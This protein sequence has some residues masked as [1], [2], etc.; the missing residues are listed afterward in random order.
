M[1]KLIGIKHKMDQSFVDDVRVPVTS[2][3]MEPC[4]ITQI[5]TMDKDGYWAVQ[6]ATEFNK[7]AKNTSKPL[8]G[9]IQKLETSKTQKYPRF[10]REIRFKEE[11][12]YKVGDYIKIEDV[13]AV[14]DTVNVIGSSKGK[15]FAGGVRRY[16]FHG[17]PKTHGQSDRHRAPGSVGQ[18][19]TPGRVYKGKRMAGRMGTDT[20]TIKNLKLISINTEKNIINLSGPVPGVPGSLIT[21]I[22]V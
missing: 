6:I 11:P 13:F 2:I 12:S 3:K 8:Q 16:G 20:K 7:K 21:V 4:L 17:G 15:G 18:T 14:G 5:K 9:K 1:N 22:K 10:I 19:T